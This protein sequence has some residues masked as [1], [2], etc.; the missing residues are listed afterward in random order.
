MRVFSTKSIKDT[1]ARL[2]DS[3]VTHD[4]LIERAGFGL[5]QFLGNPRRVAIII[6]SGNNGADGVS[7]AFY[8][9]DKGVKVDIFT[10]GEIRSEYTLFN[11]PRLITMGVVATPLS[12]SEDLSLYD[13]VV[14][15]IFGIGLSRNIEGTY[16]EAILKINAEARYVVSADIPSGICADTGKVMSVGVKSNMTVSFSGPKLGYYLSDGLDYV[17]DVLYADTGILPTEYEAE[18][19][20]RVS[21]PKRRKNTHKGDYGKI[22]IIGGSSKYVGAP[23]LAERSAKASLRSGSGLVKL[24]VPYSM[25]EVYQNR[26]MVE[27]LDFLPDVDGSIVFSKDKLDELISWSDVVVVGMG[28][29]VS[30]DI[31]KMVTYLI[32][33]AKCVVLDADAINSIADD[34]DILK[35]GIRVVITPHLGEFSRLIKKDVKYI[36]PLADAKAFACE[37]GITIHLKGATSITV[38]ESGDTYLTSSGT[39]A[40]AKG[41]SGDV[42]AGMVASF[43]GQDIANPVATASFIHGDAGRLASLK[44]GEMGTLACDIPDKIAESI[45]NHTKN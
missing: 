29:G 14:D 9:L 16:K 3:G 34:P 45:R 33:N 31:K 44:F 6:G 26:V 7:T 38:Y 39:P 4:T 24:C 43:I 32:E 37:Y 10:V 11:L 15:C 41:G 42:L 22:T 1:E 35:K 12:T 17:G 25:R 20:T 27:T 28:L 18:L 5:S 8:L 36:D 2:F 40:L 13:V 30:S 21:F 19:L 23:I